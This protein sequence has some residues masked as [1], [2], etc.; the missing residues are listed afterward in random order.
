MMKITNLV[1]TASILT[2]VSSTAVIASDQVVITE[3]GVGTFSFFK[4]AQV[5]AEVGTTGY[6]GAISYNPHPKVGLTVGYNGGNISWSDDISVN[7]TKYDLEMDNNLAYIN[8]E[9]RPWANWFYVAAGVGYI[10]NDYAVESR[11][12]ANGTIKINGFNY[13]TVG[14]TTGTVN[15]DLSYKNNLAPYVGIGFSPS[16]TSRWGIFGEIGAYYNGNPTADLASTSNFVALD[17]LA[18]SF[19]DALANEE[20]AMREDNKYEWLPV[21]KLGLSF[22]F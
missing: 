7:G 22:R 8:A 6:G 12:D 14:G 4:P 16:I 3:Q 13:Q 2:L 18:P 11:T 19:N 17:P 5:R 20:R 10:D 21:A 15:G 1:I 9:L